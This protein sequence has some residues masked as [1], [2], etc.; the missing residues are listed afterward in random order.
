M[1][2]YSYSCAEFPGM[3]DCP[4]RVQ[5]KTE[6][7]LWELIKTHAQIAHG[8]DVSAWSGEDIALVENLFKVVE[9]RS[10]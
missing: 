8:E 9:Q 1:T 10:K 4:G 5:A 7:E 3:E 2:A 6:S